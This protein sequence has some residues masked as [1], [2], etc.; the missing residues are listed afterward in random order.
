MHDPHLRRRRRPL[1]ASTPSS[2]PSSSIT[3]FFRAILLL[4]GLSLLLSTII[5]P[6]LILHGADDNGSSSNHVG[7]SNQLLLRHNSK[8]VIEAFVKDFEYEKS[9]LK[10]GVE[11]LGHEVKE[12]MKKHGVKIPLFQLSS[13]T[14]DEQQKNVAENNNF[15]EKEKRIEGAEEGDHDKE[16]RSKLR[17]P[18]AAVASDNNINAHPLPKNVEIDHNDR[19][20]DARSNDTP[21]NNDNNNHDANKLPTKTSEKPL[22][23]GAVA[24]LPLSQ[25][26]ALEGAQR[27]TIHCEN[28]NGDNDFDASFLAYWNEPQGT[29]DLE[30]K[31]PFVSKED[32]EEK[33]ISFEPDRGGWNNIRMTLETIFIIAAA[34]GR[35]L[36]LPPDQPLYLL[37]SD[38]SKKQRGFADF[39]PVHS[40]SFEKS[41]LKII[42]TEEF[43]RREGGKHGRLPI[44]DDISEKVLKAQNHCEQRLKSDISCM[45]LYDHLRSVGTVP[46]LKAGRDCL[47]FDVEKFNDEDITADHEKDV[48]NFCSGREVTYVKRYDNDP[49]LIHFQTSEKEYRLLSHFYGF[50]HFTDPA[51]DNYYKRF[52]RDYM[53]YIDP[54]FCAAGKIIRSLQKESNDRGFTLDHENGGGYSS[55]H[56]RRGEL[57]YKKVKISAEEWYENTKDLWEENEILFI[58]T[59]E[60]NKT[61]FDPIKE[62]HDVRFLDDYWDM[63]G[64]GDLDPNFMGMIDTIVASRGR[65]FAGTYFSTFTG[66]IVRMRGYHGMSMKDSYYGSQKYKNALQ[67][68]KPHEGTEFSHEW[69]SGWIGIDGDTVPSQDKF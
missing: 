49:I 52:V 48:L 20:G 7:V 6:Y 4:S 23:R 60:R 17:H 15:V 55:L 53:H 64:L 18:A 43:L 66:Y 11:E 36:V 41:K 14:A 39:F 40:S 21:N 50:V 16:T 44:E 61:F 57:Q 10:K 31:S 56:V 63:A 67:E 2:T 19:K 68:W 26:P 38:K 5:L 51:I 46:Q 62:H 34:S 12:E 9:V 47:I 24:A 25:T 22:A 69:P 30:F 29:R 27:A 3:F 32:T 59:D 28:N 37:K 42:T 65:I 45:P 13:S 33:Y 54:I 1:A 58:A 35:T 8:A